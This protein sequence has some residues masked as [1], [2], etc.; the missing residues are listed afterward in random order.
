M[1]QGLDPQRRALRGKVLGGDVR[2]SSRSVGM[3]GVVGP[4]QGRV[5]ACGAGCGAARR[6]AGVARSVQCRSVTSHTTTGE[7]GECGTRTGIR[8]LR[9][10]FEIFL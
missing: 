2:R 10:G 7:R 6:A 3:V 1:E 8:A 9:G 5:C 4:V